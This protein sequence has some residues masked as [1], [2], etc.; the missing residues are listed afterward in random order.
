MEPPRDPLGSGSNS[1]APAPNL[2]N[3]VW[4]DG[5]AAVAE[6]RRTGPQTS[7]KQAGNK[8][9]TA[10]QEQDRRRTGADLAGRPAAA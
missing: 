4:L 1:A 3:R 6:R 10:M 2:T 9:E 7:R 5:A 8:G